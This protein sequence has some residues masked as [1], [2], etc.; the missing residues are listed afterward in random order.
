MFAL[1][2]YAMSRLFVERMLALGIVGPI[3]LASPL[4][5]SMMH[6]LRDYSKAP[7]IV[8]SAFFI[9]AAILGR[10]TRG[11]ILCATAA[12][13]VAGA[14]LG[15]PVRRHARRSL[16][17]VV[18]LAGLGLTRERPRAAFVLALG[19]FLIAFAL[20]GAAR[21]SSGSVMAA[22]R[23]MSRCSA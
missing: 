7:F 11:L 20:A 16:F 17:T 18:A 13:G 2:V 22:S 12:G 14:G 5:L 1:A 3:S 19:G 6:A 23:V 9:G 8:G 21:F 15:F 4:H 10:A